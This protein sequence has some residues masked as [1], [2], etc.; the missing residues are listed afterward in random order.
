[1]RFK[2]ILLFITLYVMTSCLGTVDIFKEIK[3]DMKKMDGLMK[4]LGVKKKEKDKTSFKP[5]YLLTKPSY[6]PSYY[7]PK[8]S[9]KPPKPSYHAPKP[10]YQVPKPSYQ[11]Q[12]PL[13]QP[14][15]PSYHSIKPSFSSSSQFHGHI[16]TPVEQNKPFTVRLGSK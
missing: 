13:Y 2:C 7:P 5:S 3:K 10:S 15:K 6:K 1:M 11:P 12:K 9:Y 14:Q 16:M 8:P 4:T